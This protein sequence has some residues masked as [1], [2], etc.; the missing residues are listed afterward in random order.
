MKKR[1]F[2]L[3]MV[4]A[5]VLVLFASCMKEKE[6]DESKIVGKWEAVIDGETYTYEFKSNHEGSKQYQSYDA[7]SLTWSLDED[8]LALR[9]QSVGSTNIIGYETYIIKSLTDSRMET[10]DKNDYSKTPII[11]KRI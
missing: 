7:Q 8:E 1:L 3:S 11:F 5:T 10:Y 4:L 6:Y 9:I 2:R